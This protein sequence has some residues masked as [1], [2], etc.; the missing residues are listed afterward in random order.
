MGVFTLFNYF[1]KVAFQKSNLR[2]F[3]LV[4]LVFFGFTQAAVAQ[5]DIT[6][7]STSM[8]S[9]CNDNGTTPDSSDDTF[10]ADI[11]I[12]FNAAP[13]SGDLVLSGDSGAQ[14]VDVSTFA[15]GVM[16]YTFPAV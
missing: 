2:F 9:V 12:V 15:P 10:T 13:A 3:S 5:C 4:L 7:I 8:I 14:S 16:S 1:F 6:G 11:T